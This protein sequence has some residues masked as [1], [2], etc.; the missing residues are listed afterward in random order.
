MGSPQYMSPEQTISARDVDVRSDIWSRGMILHEMLTGAAMYTA[1]SPTAVLIM[2]STVP[3]TP[4]RSL[5]QDAPAELERALLRCL[6]KDRTNRY[7]DVAAFARAIGRF[8]S[9]RRRPYV[10]RIARI[11]GSGGTG[12]V[13]AD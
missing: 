10:D 9:E 8:A 4:L 11:L 3:A 6:E 13:R 7:P 12:A 5:R 2:I 1:E